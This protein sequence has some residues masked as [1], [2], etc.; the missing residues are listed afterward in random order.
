MV[1]VFLCSLLFLFFFDLSAQ[2]K[3]NLWMSKNDQETLSKIGVNIPIPD[4]F[5][6]D[7]GFECFDNNPELGKAFT[8]VNNKLI[9][10][11][12]E[13]IVFIPIDNI[14]EEQDSI[15]I[16]KFFGR[17]FDPNQIHTNNL[18]QQIIALTENDKSNWDKALTYLDHDEA[19]DRF[20]A[21]SVMYFQVKLGNDMI[22]KEKFNNVTSLVFQKKDRGFL[23]I[24]MLHSDIWGWT[25]HDFIEAITHKVYY[26][27]KCR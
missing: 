19:K 16:A 5:I 12:G 8:C 21:D 11:D 3:N 26:Q 23:N 9:S 25:T 17:S 13:L 1:K 15:F 14:L 4:G 2:E 7:P 10:Q 22:Y 27:D 20:N 18:K 24:I 6:S